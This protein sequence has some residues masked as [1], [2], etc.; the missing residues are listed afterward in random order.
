MKD[1]NLNKSQKMIALYNE[2]LE[3]KEIAKLLN[4][5]YNFVYNVVSNY[6]RINELQLTTG[7]SES[8]KDAIIEL[9]KAG[10]S[11]TEISKTLKTNYNY[12]AKVV[13]EYLKTV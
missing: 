6:C 5:R 4:V 2:K 3:I 9:V 8:K 10:N 11:N 12:V 1:E 13:K 7:N